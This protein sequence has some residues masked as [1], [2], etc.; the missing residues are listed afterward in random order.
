[1]EV[2]HH[3]LPLSGPHV[4]KDTVYEQDLEN[5]HEIAPWQV[6]AK[7]LLPLAPLVINFLLGR[8]LQSS[9]NYIYVG[10]KLGGAVQ[11]VL[12]KFVLDP[13]LGTLPLQ[14]RTASSAFCS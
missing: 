7:K 9:N 6:L 3:L 2:L 10:C 11:L 5:M 14:V 1:M 13:S 8:K 4:T 12:Y